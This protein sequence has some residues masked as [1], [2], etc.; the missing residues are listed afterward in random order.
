MLAANSRH[1][2]ADSSVGPILILSVH[3]TEEE[4]VGSNVDISIRAIVLPR[5]S[6]LRLCQRHARGGERRRS[7][8]I[9]HICSGSQPVLAAKRP[10]QFLSSIFDSRK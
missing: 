1:H 10:A 8:D 3:T 6:K 7:E 2:C 5:K 4:C 9:P